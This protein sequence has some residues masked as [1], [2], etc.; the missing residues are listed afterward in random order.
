MGTLPVLILVTLAVLFGIV[1][2]AVTAI[3][4]PKKPT[5]EKLAPYECGIQ[6]IE[7]PHRRFPVKY[8]L[9]GML[10]IAFD[11]EVV[12]FYPLAVLMRQL[13]VFGLIELLVFLAVLAVGYLYVWRKGAFTWE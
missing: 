1:V 13:Q 4:G 5:P 2:M 12:S 8:L 6:E 3:L 10:F 7:A 11:I 9:T